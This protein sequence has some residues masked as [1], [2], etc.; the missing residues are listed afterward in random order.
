MKKEQFLLLVVAL[1]LVVAIFLRFDQLFKNIR[2]SNEPTPVVT[3]TVNQENLDN[4]V[5]EAENLNQEDLITPPVFPEND[6]IA[7]IISEPEV[8][9][10]KPIADETVTSPLIIE[11]EARGFWF[12]EASLPIKLY[13]ADD[14]LLVSHYGEAQGDWMT[15]DFVP[16]KSTLVFQTEAERGYLEILE[17]VWDYNSDPLSNSIETHIASLRRKINFGSLPDLIHTF[18]GRGYKLALKKTT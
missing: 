13:T 1:I 9:L 16:F 3:E 17:N 14:E 12:F 8:V 6:L 7:N 11:G 2:K 5:I 4:E 18:P 10:F 15:E